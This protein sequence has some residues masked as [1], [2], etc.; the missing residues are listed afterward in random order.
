MV[1]NPLFYVQVAAVAAPVVVAAPV[2]AEDTPVRPRKA[3][4]KRKHRQV[5]SEPETSEEEDDDAPPAVS[6]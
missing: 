6:V 2:Q 1:T 3:I 4:Q 5:V